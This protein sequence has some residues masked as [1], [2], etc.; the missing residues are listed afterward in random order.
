MTCV[1]I[2][3]CAIAFVVA[4]FALAIFAGKYMHA[5]GAWAD[6]DETPLS[7]PPPA[8]PEQARRGTDRKSVV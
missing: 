7:Y 6:G 4:E 1:K 8:C 3:A 5:G 2:I